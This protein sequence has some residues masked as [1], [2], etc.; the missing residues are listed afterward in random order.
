MKSPKFFMA[1][2]SLDGIGFNEITL[3]GLYNIHETILNHG[4]RPSSAQGALASIDYYDSPEL[5]ISSIVRSIIK[6]HYFP[7]E[8]KGQ[9]L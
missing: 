1:L 7:M 8:I 6:G 9:L 4:I 2:A 3:E 5:K